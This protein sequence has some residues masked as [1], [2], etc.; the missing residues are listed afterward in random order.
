MFLISWLLPLAIL[1]PLMI[2]LAINV[3]VKDHL[4]AYFIGLALA[5]Y[6][7]KIDRFLQ[8]KEFSIKTIIKNLS[9]FDDD[10]TLWENYFAVMIASAIIILI[11]SYAF[12]VFYP[13]QMLI[14][15]AGY[16]A[17]LFA[18]AKLPELAATKEEKA[19][20]AKVK[21]AAAVKVAKTPA[22]K[23]KKVPAEK[24]EKTTAVKA[25]KAPAAKVEKTPAV[26]AKKVPA[27]KVEK[28]PAVKVKKATT[29]T[30]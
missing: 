10:K 29:K 14:A 6:V 28:A 7:T 18:F 22:A 24:V 9:P 19:T 3:E 13:K 30:K 23:A 2:L 27:A 20:A 12:N 16:A 1:T 26:K 21:K 5:T 25:K 15:Y 8:M 11:I 4:S 17:I